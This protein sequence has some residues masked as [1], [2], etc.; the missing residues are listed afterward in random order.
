MWLPQY[1][2]NI[3]ESG[4]KHHNLNPNLLVSQDTF[5]IYQYHKLRS[6]S[7]NAI[8]YIVYFSMS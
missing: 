8:S 4:V 2:W 6:L 5:F 3:V 7:Y 1:N